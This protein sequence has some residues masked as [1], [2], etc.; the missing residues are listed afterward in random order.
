MSQADLRE[1]NSVEELE[2]ALAASA[3]KA[4]LIFKHSL[5]CSI[6]EGAYEQLQQHLEKD[7]SAQVDYLL[8][9]V[10]TARAASNAAAAQL[11]VEHES[12]QAI[13]VEDG[14]AVWHISH[15]K[16][17]RAALGDA[18]KAHVKQG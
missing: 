5:T 14:R 8:I 16:I 18:I 11:G 9:A 15:R 2:R 4:Q 3:N 13:L 6:S 17:T 12:P 1:I 10:Q 7:A